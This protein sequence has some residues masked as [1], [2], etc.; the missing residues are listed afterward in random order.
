MLVFDRFHVMKLV[1]EKLAAWLRQL[2][3][4]ATEK[5]DKEVLKGTRWLLLKNPENLD[6]KK[7]ERER[8]E[9]ALRMNQPLATV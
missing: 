7:K 3:R 8:L 1:N 2:Y 4:E 6:P 5:M 9:E